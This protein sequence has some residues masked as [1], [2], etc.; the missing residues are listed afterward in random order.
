MYRDSKQEKMAAL[1]VALLA[2][3]VLGTGCVINFDWE[4]TGYVMTT[5]ALVLSLFVLG[6]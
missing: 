4:V 1:V 5:L 3:V 6:R 2:L